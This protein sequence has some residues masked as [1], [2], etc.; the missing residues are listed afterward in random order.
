MFWYE[1]VEESMK[2]A[3]D[4][5]VEIIIPEKSLFAE[6]SKSVVEDFMKEFPEMAPIVNK[7]KNH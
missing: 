4:W 7:I 6:K 3:K 5:G 1:S 2:V